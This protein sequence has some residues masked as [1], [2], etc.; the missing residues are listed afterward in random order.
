MYACKDGERR[1]LDRS[2]HRQTR[3]HQLPP[4]ATGYLYAC[5]SGSAVGMK[6]EATGLRQETASR[7]AVSR[8][9]PVASPFTPTAD[10]LPQAYGWPVACDGSWCPNG[11]LCTVVLR[12]IHS[13][14]SVFIS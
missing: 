1:V 8:L 12:S 4:Q 2:S 11:R 13:P 10:P 7:Y 6:G 14:L 9:N 3:E 5:G